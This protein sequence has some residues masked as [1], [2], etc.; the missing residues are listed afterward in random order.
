[1]DE[2]RTKDQSIDTGSGGR[3]IHVHGSGTG[4]VESGSFVPE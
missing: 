4:D 3:L 1:V 2:H